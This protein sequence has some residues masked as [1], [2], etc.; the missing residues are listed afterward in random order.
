MRELVYDPVKSG[1]RMT[2]I[3]FISGSG[4][5]YREIVDSNPDH[6][7]IV[8]TNRPGCGG[9]GIARKNNHKVLELSHIPYLKEARKKH[10]PGKVPRN[11]PE[12]IQYE[13]D[14][15]HLIEHEIGRQPD[16]ICLAGY[17]QLN[18]DYMVD[19]YYPRILNVHPGD[20][21]KGYVGLHT[22]PFAMAI[23]TGEDS[24]RS[25]LFFID[26]NMDNGPVLVQSA[27]L[28][29]AKT[30]AELDAKQPRKLIE[31]LHRVLAFAGASRI[32]TYEEFM[33]KADEELQQV[34]NDICSNLQEALKVE[35]DW[36]IYP[37]AVQLI[38]KGRVK[39][40]GREVF[41]DDKKLP[42]YGFR[43]G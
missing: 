39:V 2:I 3:C 15:C 19:K 36:K 20:T 8:F 23:L 13:K 28:K 33:E 22:I 31:G 29:I 24:V 6:D 7:Y 26:K 41:L 10:G 38:S 12:R 5:N 18:T 25:T 37:V 17:D 32:T 16:L 11:A 42:E 1:K 4:T 30:L 40:I 21:T 14:L 34:M 27:P 9:T 35:G 43:L